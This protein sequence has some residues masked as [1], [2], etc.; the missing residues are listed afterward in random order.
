MKSMII[1][2]SF[3]MLVFIIGCENKTI[4]ESPDLTMIELEAIVK[5]NS[6]TLLEAVEQFA[7]DNYGEYP[8]SANSDTALSGKTLIDYLP[9]GERLVNPFTGQYDQ[10]IA[11][12]PSSPG[13]I[14]YYKYHPNCNVYYIQG[15]GAN[16]IIIEH[17]NI[18]EIEALIMEDCLSLQQ[19]VEKW[20]DDFSQSYYPCSNHESNNLGYCVTDYLPDGQYMQNHFTLA[21]VEPTAWGHPPGA[22]G[23]IGYECILENS[24]PIGYTISA[25]GFEPEVVIFK[26]D[27]H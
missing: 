15:Y 16:S 23:T 10:P 1:L 19:A 20:H 2:I 24:T 8:A 14:G 26:I 27:V 12:V 22:M 13:E 5:G 18:I 17:D 3:I 21:P 6:I 4:V 9:G 11:L 7:L 25:I